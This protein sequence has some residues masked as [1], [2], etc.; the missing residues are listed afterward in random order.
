[1]RAPTV[2]AARDAESLTL[3]KSSFR[4]IRRLATPSLGWRGPGRKQPVW[5]S[6]LGRRETAEGPRDEAFGRP[7]RRN[8]AAACATKGKRAYSSR[9]SVSAWPGTGS[10]S[11][12]L[13]QCVLIEFQAVHKAA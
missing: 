5:G 6:M 12:A 4:V 7:R 13:P 10:E 8:A 3:F 1:M 9:R 11:R 2:T